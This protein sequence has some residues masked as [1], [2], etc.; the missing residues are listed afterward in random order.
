MQEKDFEIYDRQ[1]EEAKKILKSFI[2]KGTLQ[3]VID[4]ENKRLENK[5]DE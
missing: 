1:L 4:E 3:I 2:K 5:V